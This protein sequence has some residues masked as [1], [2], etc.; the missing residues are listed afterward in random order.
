MKRICV[1]DS[2]YRR[3]DKNIR[4]GQIERSLTVRRREDGFEVSE[5][6]EDKIGHGTAILTILQQ[7]NEKENLY[8]ILKIFDSELECDEELLIYALQYVYEKM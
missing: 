1:I 4:K 6:A 5:G 8:T 3:D 2:G 7:G